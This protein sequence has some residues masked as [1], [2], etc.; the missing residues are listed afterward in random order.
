M[1]IER[2]HVVNIAYLKLDKDCKGCFDRHDLSKFFKSCAKIEILTGKL[3]ISVAVNECF[4]KF[5][6]SPTIG[7]IYKYQFFQYYKILSFS[8]IH[9]DEFIG[10]VS[11]DWCLS[12]LDIV[13]MTGIES[14]SQ[15]MKVKPTPPMEDINYNREISPSL[16]TRRQGM[17]DTSS[18]S[19]VNKNLSLVACSQVVGNL[20]S[21][22]NKEKKSSQKDNTQNKISNTSLTVDDDIALKLPSVCETDENLGDTPSLLHS[23]LLLNESITV[24]NTTDGKMS[25]PSFVHTHQQHQ[26][27]PSFNEISYNSSTST[28]VTK[29]NVLE[30]LSMTNKE[31]DQEEEKEKNLRN[32]A[33]LSPSNLIL[34]S[35]NE[36]EKQVSNLI[37]YHPSDNYEMTTLQSKAVS[38][39]L[40]T[41]K[42]G[43]KTLELRFL[44]KKP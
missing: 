11:D 33:D 14:R 7:T 31:I 4:K 3:K 10:K 43:I 25:G 29:E 17:I 38:E 27:Q 35:F 1:S 12:H 44:A 23:S 21:L 39:M 32:I 24:T 20:M 30:M 22:V 9:D 42:A 41:I 28:L 5:D 6:V 36:I 19:G 8:I 37:N 26:Q 34:N 15:S 2:E 40:D 18:V 13:T 16:K